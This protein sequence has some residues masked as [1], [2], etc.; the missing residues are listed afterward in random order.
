MAENVTKADSVWRR[1]KYRV[2]PAQQVQAAIKAPPTQ[3]PTT[4][5]E[6]FAPWIYLSRKNS[7]RVLTTMRN[8]IVIPA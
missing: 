4:A 6:K 7:T 3:G 1:K 2:T 8:W 5:V